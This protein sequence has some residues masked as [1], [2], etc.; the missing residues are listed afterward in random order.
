V[1]SA[2]VPD[3]HNALIDPL[4]PQTAKIDAATVRKWIYDP[5]VF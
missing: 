3:E 4:H 1:P 2:I 5:R